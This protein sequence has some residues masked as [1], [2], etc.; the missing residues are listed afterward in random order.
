MYKIKLTLDQRNSA[1]PK[2]DGSLTIYF[3][4]GLCITSNGDGEGGSSVSDGRHNNGG[5]KALE[6]PTEI[7][8]QIDQA[9]ERARK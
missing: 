5:W 6:S 8:R 4:D 3:A 1:K 9:I 2:R 7:E